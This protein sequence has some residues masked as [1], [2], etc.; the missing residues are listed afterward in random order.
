MQYN[1][2][3]VDLMYVQTIGIIALPTAS[4]KLKEHIRKD[5]GGL[6]LCVLVSVT[7]MFR[8]LFYF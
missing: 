2:S 7:C 1:T 6:Y 3:V 4:Q 5:H 8:K